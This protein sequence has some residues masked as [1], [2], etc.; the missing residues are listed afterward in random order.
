L[1]PTGSSIFIYN[2]V[3]KQL[4]DL[5]AHQQER[6][7]MDAKF[8]PDGRFVSYICNNDI[9]VQNLKQGTIHTLTTSGENC[10]NGVAEFIM[11]EEFD[12]Y[13][14]Y[15]WDPTKYNTAYRISYLEVDESQ[16]PEIHIP[17]GGMDSKCDTYRY[18]RAGQHNAKSTLCVVEFDAS[19]SSVKMRRYDLYESFPWF[20]YV[21][22][23]EWTPD[24]LIWLTLLDRKQQRSA[25]ITLNPE[26]G[27][28]R[29]ILEERSNIW[30]NVKDT[31]HFLG[32]G[33][34][35]YGNET[36]TGYNHL[37]VYSSSD[38]TGSYRISKTITC[39][40]WQVD[41][42]KENSNMWIDEDRSLVYFYGSKDTP[43][44]T[45]IYYASFA[46]AGDVT[47]IT[48]LGSSHASVEFNSSRTRMVCTRSN[49]DIAPECLIYC[50]SESKWMKQYIVEYSF[51]PTPVPFPLTRPHLFS[52]I[53]SSNDLLFGCYY[54]PPNY[55]R[56]RSYPVILYV[57]GGPKVQLVNQSYQMHANGRLQLLS[58]LGFVVISIDGRGSAR[59]GL[60]FEGNLRNRM[61]QFEILDQIEGI[62]Y[63][64]KNSI[65]NID[66][67]RIGVFGWSYGG[68]LALMALAQYGHFFKVCV[69]GAPVTMWELY[70]TG[71]T[72][73]YMD[74]PHDNPGG[75]EFGS[76]LHYVSQLPDD[77]EDRLLILCG[78]M[79]ENVHLTHTTCLIDSMVNYGKSYSLS[80][81]PNE[82]HGIRSHSSIIHYQMRLIQFMLKH[83]K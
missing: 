53:N 77:G 19:F 74:T 83:L 30:V 41:F 33:R 44:E 47:R 21:M 61:G 42:A 29:I 56:T 82:R 16:V 46:E 14:G 64:I 70:D 9:F 23:S 73:R 22:R 11:Q 80:V 58:S 71:Y 37:Y 60:L 63:L 62:E 3:T 4:V 6:A 12:R 81:Y 10:T 35:I 40:N 2:L 72:E 57:Y 13:T 5:T 25:L 27:T 34:L 66:R 51:R 15:W 59:R 24:G 79:D 49:V 8:S 18:P 50:L 32:D 45:H 78:M 48:D 65:I 36:I 31:I 43:L 75:Y 7:K 54:F 55:D 69:A 52:F 67:T 26:T 39:G 20:E 17:C 68:Y 76:V 38:N 28:T 1:I